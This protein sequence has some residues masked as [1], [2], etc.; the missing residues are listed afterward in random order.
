MSEA[1]E[2][3][4]LAWTVDVPFWLTNDV[5][6]W[7]VHWASAVEYATEEFRQLMDPAGLVP[8]GSM[9]VTW[10][11]LWLVEGHDDSGVWRSYL[12][13]LQT[14]IHLLD[15]AAGPLPRPAFVHVRFEL[16]AA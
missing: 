8:V 10:E 11:Y 1:R 9:R 5:A 15:V 2:V 3:Q 12:P 4:R 16:D 7:D 6:A 13:E 14:R